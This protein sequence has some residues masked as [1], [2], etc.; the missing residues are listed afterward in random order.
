MVKKFKKAVE[1]YKEKAK[2]YS[3][4]DEHQKKHYENPEMKWECF[5]YPEYIRTKKWYAGAITAVVLLV[6][7]GLATNSW[8]FSIVVLI[9]A[10]VY[11]YLHSD[12][13]PVIEIKISDIGLKVGQRVYPFTDLKTFWIDYQPPNHQTLNLVNKNQ[14]KEEVSVQMHGQNPSEVRRILTQYLPEWEE[15]EKNLTESLTNFIGL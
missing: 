3:E 13:T 15:R 10:G 12:D 9:T 1:A 5:L 2:L 6:I 11:Y 8:T 14:Y 4:L 7:Y